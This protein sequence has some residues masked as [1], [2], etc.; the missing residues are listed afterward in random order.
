MDDW[1][2]LPE[3]YRGRAQNRIRELRKSMEGKKGRP[4]VEGIKFRS[5]REAE[6]FL[7]LREMESAHL[8]SHLM[9]H[10]EMPLREGGYYR[11]PSGDWAKQKVTNLKVSFMYWKKNQNGQWMPTIMEFVRPSKREKGL[12]LMA[13]K[14]SRYQR[15]NIREVE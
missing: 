12:I 7:F 2:R 13:R 5:M 11:R 8:I 4:E 14:D 10:W 6:R 3:I 1:G 9:V 15:F